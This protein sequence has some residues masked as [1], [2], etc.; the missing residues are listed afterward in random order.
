METLK[1]AID[2]VSA[3]LKNVVEQSIIK[4]EHI[5]TWR[6]SQ[7]LQQSMTENYYRMGVRT[8]K[9]Y[10]RQ[11]AGRAAGSHMGMVGERK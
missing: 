7:L 3:G 10:P 8:E 1:I 6:G 5:S 9:S 11:N 4:T 2:D